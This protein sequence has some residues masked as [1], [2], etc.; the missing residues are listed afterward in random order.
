M[1]RLAE[2]GTPRSDEPTVTTFG[3]FLTPGFAPLGVFAALE[4]LRTA[5]RFLDEPHYGW[6]VYSLD[7]A[8]VPSTNGVA[9]NADGPPAEGAKIDHLFVCAGYHPEN[10]GDKKTLAWIR[11]LHRHG[12]K[13]GAISTGTHILAAA[14]VI[15]E[16]RCTIHSDNEASLRE[17]FPEVDLVDGVFE[18][19]RGLYTCAGGTAAI[20]LFIHLVSA[21]HGEQ[22]AAAIAHQFQQDRVRNSADHQSKQKRVG[23]RLR[24]KKL[25][26]ALDIMERNIE[27]PLNPSEL[28]QRIGVTPRHLQRLFKKHIGRAPRDF[29]LH[30]RLNHGRLLLLQTSLSIF[31]VAVASGFVSHAHFTSCYRQHF[32]YPPRLERERVQ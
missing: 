21:D 3:F 30:L 18:I 31:E 16:R 12:T 26:E 6:K 4:V 28:A 17:A 32:G 19:D 10:Y 22:F 15:G 9:V 7:G 2:T 5:N 1:H 27:Q 8:P 14:G 13:V 29:Y 23:L 24:S 20:D 25:A 11:S